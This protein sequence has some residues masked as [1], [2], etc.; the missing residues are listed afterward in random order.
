MT[1]T[2]R[3]LTLLQIL[4]ESRYP[5]TAESL[6]SQLH[7]SIRSV[8][9]DIDE[10]RCQG[11]EITGEAGI[12]YQLKSGLLLPPLMFDDNELEAL[13]LGLRWVQSNADEE[14]KLSAMRAINK[15]N[16]V[17]KQGSQNLINQT[18]LFAPSTQIAPINNVIAKNL[19]LSL[20]KEIKAK[21]DYQDEN[22]KFSS[23]VIW[24][25]AIG[26]MKDTQVLAAWC[27][28][29]ESYR[30]FRLDRIQSYI[31]LED[32]LPYPKHYLFE[33]WRKETLCVT[34]DRI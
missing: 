16:A 14:L 29:R 23:R 8:Y 32:K 34:T 11:A 13:I 19:R 2:Q 15:I 17:V 18:T 4:K 12:G 27:E 30:H 6:A 3:L 31:A 24:P 5:I 1:R 7:I 20:R 25:I 21:I 22:G 10:L 28:L 9:R 26:Y 33:Q